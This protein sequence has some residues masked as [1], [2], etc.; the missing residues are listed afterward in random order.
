M[1]VP[2]LGLSFTGVL[3]KTGEYISDAVGEKAARERELLAK[4]KAENPSGTAFD[5]LKDPG[6][7]EKLPTWLLPV[8]AVA[9]VGLLLLSKGGGNDNRK[10]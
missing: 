1:Y 2:E 10:K 6:E 5:P 4:A 7:G 8:G 9:V 3:E